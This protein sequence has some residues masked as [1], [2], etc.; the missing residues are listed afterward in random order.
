MNDNFFIKMYMYNYFE[1][2][3]TFDNKNKTKKPSKIEACFNN[4]LQY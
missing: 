4:C 3:A 2:N 1:F